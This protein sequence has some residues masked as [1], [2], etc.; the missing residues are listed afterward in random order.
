MQDQPVNPLTRLLKN[1]WLWLAVIAVVV[2]WIIISLVINSKFRVTGTQPGLD[3]VAAATPQL[4]INFNRPLSTN[5]LSV[6]STP[7]IIAGQKISG[8]SLLLDLSP[9]NAGQGYTITVNSISSTD[10]AQLS[11]QVF[12]FKAKNIAFKDLPKDEQQLILQRQSQKPG[13]LGFNYQNF[14]KLLDHGV[15]VE[16]ESTLKQIIYRYAQTLKPPASQATLDTASLGKPPRDPS[17]NVFTILF[18]LSV[19]KTSYSAKLEYFGAASVHLLLND[20]KT[21]VLVFDSNSVSSQSTT[22]D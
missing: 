15:S 19:D 4:S 17:S 8:Q 3:G 1:G 21:G 22:P 20:P 18:N 11:H 5:N 2:V 10:G 6:D 14:D 9:L 7:S 13:P 16:Q 12:S